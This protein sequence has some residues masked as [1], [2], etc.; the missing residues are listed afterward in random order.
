MANIYLELLELPEKCRE[1]CIHISYGVYHKID[2]LA[3]CNLKH[4]AN[5]INIKK[6]QY[7]NMKMEKHTPTIVSPENLL[8]FEQGKE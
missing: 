4:I 5:P 2:F 8:V 1:D 3:T 7:E 6:I